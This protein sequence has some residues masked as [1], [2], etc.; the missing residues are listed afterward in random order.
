MR[1]SV[2]ITSYNQKDYL[3]Q[4]IDSVLAQTVAPYEIIICDDYSSD[5]SRDLIRQ[6]SKTYKRRVRAIF[7]E[8]NLGVT[9]NRNSGL[10]SARGDYITT[11]DGDDLYLPEKLD[12][13][14]RKAKD[15]NAPLVYSNILYINEEG[16]ET[17]IRYKNNRQLE[18]CLFEEIATLKYPAPRE[19]LIKRSCIEELGYQ[20]ESLEINED[21]EWIA[22]LSS[23]YPFATVKEP[24]AKHRFHPNGLHQS[25]R[26]LLLETL[27]KVT[28]KM[29]IYCEKSIVRNKLQTRK[30]ISAFS[31]LSRAR[32]EMHQANPSQAIRSVQRSISQDWLRSSSYDLYMRLV[33]PKLF[34][35]QH[36][37]ADQLML[38]P[39][40]IPFYLL[41]GLF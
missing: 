2:V 6:Y 29:V 30:A 17:G 37:I 4:A 38:G 39:L 41:R 20:D 25:G 26:L 1:V 10:K 31:H 13:E 27:A 16:Q 24:L 7:H 33:M 32:I 28:E 19:V 18:G 9:R 23:R 12:K 35:R 8:R 22:R 15:S 3:T 5:G 21:F 34:K 40:P 11:L 36:R 14:M